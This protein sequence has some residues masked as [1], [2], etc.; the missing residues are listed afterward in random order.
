MNERIRITP[1]RLIDENGEMVGVVDTD[2]ARRRAADLGLDLVEMAA[3]VRPPVCRI[4]DYGKYRFEQRKKDRA[5]RARSKGSELKEVRLGRSMKIDPH[6]VGIRMNQARKFLMAGHRVQI[7]QNFRGAREMAHR[8]R[9]D[10]R[11][12][13]VI[14]QLADIS[15]V[16]MP[17]RLNG[18]RMNMILVP[19]RPRIEAIKRQQ[20][21]E[22]AAAEAPPTDADAEMAAETPTAP[23]PETSPVETPASSEST[24]STS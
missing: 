3:D 1:I 16:E 2:E 8:D 19:D 24:T 17:P 20:A 18:R 11:M 9:G 22:A 5:G 4:M 21:A 7:V 6:D 14:E 12:R 13:E 10:I 23:A 15:K